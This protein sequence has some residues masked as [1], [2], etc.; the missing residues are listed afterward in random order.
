MGAPIFPLDRVMVITDYVFLE[1]VRRIGVAP[2]E[3]GGPLGG[4]GH[5][6][7]GPVTRFSFDATGRCSG[8]TYSPNHPHLNRIFR[9]QWNPVD[10]YLRGFAHSHPTGHTQPSGGDLVYTEAILRAIPELGQLYL[11]I[12][13]SAHGGKA[14]E[15]FSYS[16]PRRDGGL[17]CRPIPIRIV[18][19]LPDHMRKLPDILQR[20]PDIFDRELEH[21]NIPPR[22]QRWRG[23]EVYRQQA[24][25]QAAPVASD[26]SGE[27]IHSSSDGQA[28]DLDRIFDRVNEVYDLPLME[29]SRMVVVGAGGAVAFLDDLARTGLGQ[30]VLIDP[31]TVSPTNIGTQQVYISDLGRPKVQC[32]KERL[33]RINPEMII[34]TH[35]VALDELDDET[36][37]ELARDELNGEYPAQTVICGFTDSFHAQARVNR[38]ALHLGLP[39]LNAQVYKEGRG[40]EISFTHPEVTPACG[41]CVLGSRY[42]YRLVQKRPNDVTSHQTPIFATTRLNALKGFISLA[43]LHHGTDHPRWGQLLEH[44][45]NRNLVQVRLDPDIA[46]TMGLSIFDKTF[47]GAHKERLLFDDVVWLPQQPENEENGFPNCPDCDGT[48]DLWHKLGTFEDTRVMPGQE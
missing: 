39:S 45:G 28:A 23:V 33:L 29:S 5:D 37:T 10:V 30:L 44:I 40:V 27:H 18:S 17:V 6:R 46:T 8:A 48:G 47:H 43:L 4:P 3:L 19:T 34:S 32:I 15:L 14:F 41:R 24:E 21:V 35:Q 26:L 36:F 7:R 2:A 31:D 25:G 42:R 11:P 13:N 12:I 9:D 22:R 20:D 1:L 38:L 16:V